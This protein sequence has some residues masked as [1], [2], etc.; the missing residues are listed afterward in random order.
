[1]NFL[2][3]AL[4]YLDQPLLAVSTGVPDWLRVVD[5]R[6]RARGKLAREHLA[7][8]DPQLRQVAGGVVRH[9]EDDRWF[10]STQAFAETNL[11][12]AV[13]LRQL[14]PGD[15]GFRPTF[16]GHILIEMLLDASWIR[17]DSTLA[18]RYYAALRAIPADTIQHC[19]NAITGKKTDKLSS[20]IER[21]IQAQFLYDYLDHRKLL[22]RLNQVLHRVALSPLPDAVGD[23]LPEARK[24]VESRRSRLLLPPD[25]H[26][27]FPQ[28]PRPT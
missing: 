1:M 26:H 25:E 7:S 15:A 19:V 14:L 12:L 28:L 21:F 6:L 3:H 5:R 11:Q 23:W 2:C 8:D 10:H 20:V 22:M 27:P 4:P 13:E 18:D 17:D 16:V 24:L 9:H